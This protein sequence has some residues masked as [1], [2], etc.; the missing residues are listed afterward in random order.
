MTNLFEASLE[1]AA[2]K[3]FEMLFLALV[4]DP[5]RD[6]FQ[7]FEAAVDRLVDV[8]AKVD[9]LMEKYKNLAK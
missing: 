9:E 2:M 5:T 4:N 1:E 7:R 3:Q 6:A 8:S